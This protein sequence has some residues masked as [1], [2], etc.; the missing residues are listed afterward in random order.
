MNGFVDITGASNFWKTKVLSEPDPSLEYEINRFFTTHFPSRFPDGKAAVVIYSKLFGSEVSGPNYLAL[1]INRNGEIVGMMSARR[2]NHKI[3]RINVNT[4]EMGDTF[5]SPEYR[6][7][8]RCEVVLGDDYLDKSVFG[9]LFYSLKPQLER[10]AELIYGIPNSEARKAW[11][12]GAGFID[13]KSNN[14]RQYT[15]YR[16]PIHRM[17]RKS[18]LELREIQDFET[19]KSQVLD[20]CDKPTI[21]ELSQKEIERQFWNNE[22]YTYS[23]FIF[24]SRFCGRIGLIGRIRLIGRRKVF[25]IAKIFGNVSPSCYFKLLRCIFSTMP[26]VDR[27][28]FLNG[29]AWFFARSFFALA[30]RERLLIVVRSNNVRLNH[31]QITSFT[32]IEFG[33]T[34]LI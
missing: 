16:L 30:R 4:Y 1:A 13:L 33:D 27:I 15:L 11:L 22:V 5:T 7:S 19:F 26:S 3:I 28:V 14:I 12:K 6:K 2:R 29:S 24:L 8:G 9:R 20:I 25:V 10:G 18:G 34:D 32:K 23:K 17:S 21:D 31:S